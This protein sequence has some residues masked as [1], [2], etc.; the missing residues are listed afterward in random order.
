MKKIYFLVSALMIMLSAHAQSY[1]E[2]TDLPGTGTGPA[3]TVSSPSITIGGT[4][5]TPNDGQDRFQIIIP[6][7]CTVTSVTWTLTDTANISVNGYAQ[8]GMMNQENIPPL[9]GSFAMAP[10]SMPFP[11]TQGTYDCM[12]VTNTAANDVWTMTFNTSC[13]NGIADVNFAGEIVVAPN[14]AA[15]KISFTGGN[16]GETLSISNAIGQT[17]ITGQLTST[18][19]EIS[20]AELPEGI[21]CFTIVSE[22][23]LRRGKFVVAR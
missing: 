3:F 9:T 5:N 11:A 21:Y 1:T 14:P 13:T 18:Q 15:E 12:M 20:V 17:V 4:L 10:N 22:G 19:Q 8:F 23:F 2:G 16:A 6:F 7:G